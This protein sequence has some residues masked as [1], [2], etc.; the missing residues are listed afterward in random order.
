V[1]ICES[2][3]YRVGLAII[4]S[5]LALASTGCGGEGLVSPSA[6][7]PV[8]AAAAPGPI[9]DPA[10][11]GLSISGPQGCVRADS[12]PAVIAWTFANVPPDSRF[13]KAYHHDEEP[14][15][16][17]TDSERRTENDHLR[18]TFTDATTALGE[19]EVFAYDCGRQLINVSIQTGANE[20]QGLIAL[21]IYHDGKPCAANVTPPASPPPPEPPPS[22]PPSPPSCDTRTFSG[23]GSVWIADKKSGQ[24][25]VK[26]ATVSASYNVGNFS[27]RVGI[28]W[29]NSGSTY[30]KTSQSVSVP[31]GQTRSGSLSWSSDWV[32]PS[33]GHVN[34]GARYYLVF[35]TGSD[36]HPSIVWERQL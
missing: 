28:Y 32:S 18:V 35:Y 25:V 31:C 6:L 23:S 17:P 1:Q 8:A 3:K 11:P 14:S 10:F 34:S 20:P 27:G 16:E 7:P 36:S 24:N 33:H 30:M 21:V 15:C 22:T 29:R 4:A 19:Y 26:Q 2:T 9:V 5:A 13:L 12:L